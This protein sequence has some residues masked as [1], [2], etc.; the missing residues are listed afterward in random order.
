MIGFGRYHYQYESGREC[1][2]F[3]TGFVLRQSGP[4]IYIMPGYH[5]YSTILTK[6]GNPCLYLKNLDKIDMM[7]LQRLIKAG[8]KDSRK[9]YVV[10]EL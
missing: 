10:Q 3:A 7:V 6:L 4:T 5:D 2:M 1:D 8:L 9:K